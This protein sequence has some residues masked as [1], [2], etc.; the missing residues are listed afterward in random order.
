MARLTP[1][2]WDIVRA[3]YE[4]RNLSNYELAEKHGVTETAI[5]KKAKQYGW[6][7]GVYTSDEKLDLILVSDT[8]TNDDGFVYLITFKDSAYK[9][10]VKIGVANNVEVR[11]KT[12]QTSTPFKLSIMGAFYCRNK[13]KVEAALHDVFKDKRMCG[14][15]FDLSDSDIFL[16]KE[17]VEFYG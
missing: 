6:V 17:K 15:W 10:Y 12:L 4:V 3:D 8:S 16:I 13:N 5:R 9:R 11:L 7:K 2:Q 14:E 1:E